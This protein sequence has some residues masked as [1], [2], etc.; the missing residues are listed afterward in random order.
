MFREREETKRQEGARYDRPSEVMGQSMG[1]VI[2][3]WE[4]R[5]GLEQEREEAEKE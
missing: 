5:R 2:S 4:P 3:Q 1:F